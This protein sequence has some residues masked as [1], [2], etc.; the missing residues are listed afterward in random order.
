MA[1]NIPGSS[2]F[3]NF[4]ESVTKNVVSAGNDGGPR[5]PLLGTFVQLPTFPKYKDKDGNELEFSTRRAP[6]NCHPSSNL[7]GS[8]KSSLRWIHQIEKRYSEEFVDAYRPGFII[9]IEAL[10]SRS[11]NEEKRVHGWC[12]T[13]ALST[14]MSTDLQYAVFPPYFRHPL[15]KGKTVKFP[16]LMQDLKHRKV[17]EEVLVSYD[18]KF[19]VIPESGGLAADAWGEYVVV[20]A[21]TL[22]IGPRKLFYVLDFEV[23]NCILNVGR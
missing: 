3:G 22:S 7:N 1:T 15:L 6:P 10:P 18:Y 13:Y 11:V 4:M 12:V 8:F 17:A 14:W 5:L 9:N 16:K 19:P 21:T 23:K 20:E 2:N